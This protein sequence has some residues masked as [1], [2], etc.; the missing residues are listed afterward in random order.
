[1]NLFAE[2]AA[3]VIIEE[4]TKLGLS[5]DFIYLNDASPTQRPF[6]AYG[7]GKSLPRLAQ[8]RDKYDPDGFLQKYLSHGFGIP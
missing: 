5:H 7:G 1:M 3:S 2:K 4:T 6:E 8:I